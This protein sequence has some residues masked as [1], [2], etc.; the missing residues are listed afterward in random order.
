MDNDIYEKLKELKIEDFIW[1]TYLGISTM[2]LYSNIIERHYVI[3]KDYIS[4]EKYRNI[5]ITIFSILILIYIYFILTNYKNYKE[6]KENNNL[7]KIKYNYL[8]YVGAIIALISGIIFLY[9]AIKNKTSDTEIE[10]A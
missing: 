4:K 2:A 6:A 5:N 3:Y 7:N 10:I 1:I 8:S 9:V